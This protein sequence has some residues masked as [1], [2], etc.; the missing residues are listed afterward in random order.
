[1]L[2]IAAVVLGREFPPNKSRVIG[3]IKAYHCLQATRDQIGVVLNQ[4]DGD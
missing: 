1:M 4:L 3:A 2:C